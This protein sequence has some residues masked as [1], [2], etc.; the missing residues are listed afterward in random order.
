MMAPDGDY[1]YLAIAL[2]QGA[3]V[4]G[5]APEWEEVSR[6]ADS[7]EDWLLLLAKSLRDPGSISNA[8]LALQVMSRRSD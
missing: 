6:V 4:H 5:C 7:F 8:P 3:V 1:D 2:A